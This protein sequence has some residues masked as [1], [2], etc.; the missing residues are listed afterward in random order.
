MLSEQE[1]RL[2]LGLPGTGTSAEM[3]KLLVDLIEASIGPSL[4]GLEVVA[5]GTV[6]TQDL[7][8]QVR[9]KAIQ[10]TEE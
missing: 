10:V 7:H 6:E 2:R 4:V 3:S 8:L 9:V 5:L 1:Y